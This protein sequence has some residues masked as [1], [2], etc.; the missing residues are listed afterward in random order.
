MIY[1]SLHNHTYYSIQDGFASPKEY[2]ER[3][4]EVGLKAIAITEHGNLYSAPYIHKLRKDYPDL[5]VIYGVEAYECLDHKV[6]DPNNRYFHLIVLAKN[7]KGRVAINKLITESEFE[8]KYYKP[9]MDLSMIKPY[10][11]DLIITSACMAS[12]LHREQDYQKCIEYINEYKSIFNKDNFYLE[13]QSHKSEE[14]AEYN[15]KI[16]KLAKETGT[17]F[18]ITTDSHAATKKQLEY[19]GIFVQI[20][21]DRETMD[22]SYEGCYMQSAEEIHEIMDEQIGW[23]YV[24]LGLETTNYI[25]DLCDQVEMPF[26]E[27]KL[28]PF[29]IPKEYTE[30]S[31]I[32]N[33]IEKGWKTRNFDK[34]NQI[35][36]KIR[37][38][39]IQ[40]ELDT[41]DK[42][43]FIGYFLIVWDY[44]NWGRNN[45]VLFGDGGRGSGAGSIICY[46]LEITGIDPVKYGLIFER[47]L[48]P[49]R[50]GLP[51]LDIDLHPKEKVI[52]YL[53]SRYGI[54]SVCQICNFSYITPNV[55]I[56]DVIRILDKDKKRL[57]K[58]GMTIGTKKSFEIAK[59]F[60]SEKWEDCIAANKTA[61]EK[62]SD[63]IFI[64][65][66]RIAKELSGRVRHVSIH[67]GGVGIVGTEIT[68]YMPMRKTDKGEHVIQVDKKIVEEIG[69][70]KFDL[71]G[72][73]TLSII[74]GTLEV[75]NVEH[76]EIDPN[77]EAFL[78]DKEMFSLIGAGDT[79]NVFQLESQGMKDL[80][81]RLKPQTIREISDILALYRPDS[82]GMLEDYIA[83]KTKKKQ[84]QYIHPDMKKILGETYSALVYQ[85]QVMEITR[86]FGGRSYAGADKFR[87]GIGKKDPAIVQKEATTLKTEIINNG[88]PENI[89]ILISDEMK[90][91]G[92]Y[93]FNKSHSMGYSVISLQT[94]YLKAH[95]QVPFYCAV[96]NACNNDNGKINKYITEAQNH[97]VEISPP[98]I[99][100]SIDNFSVVDGK[101]LFGIGAIN[102][103]GGV[104]VEKIIKERN[105]GKYTGV[106]NFIERVPEV[107]TAQVVMLIKAGAFGTQNK[108][109]L[110][111]KYLKYVVMQKNDNE[112]KEY[113][114]VK[115]LPTLLVLKL[116]YGIDTDVIK[117]KEERLKLYNQIRTERHDTIE[118]EQ[119]K[120]EQKTRQKKEYHKLWEKYS[121]NKDYWE[122]EAI[123]IFLTNNPFRNIYQC[124][125][126][127]FSSAENGQEFFDVGIIS[128]ITKKK[129]KYK[130]TFCFINLY[131]Y[132]GIIE[133]LCFAT[134]YE[135]F[136]DLIAKGN[137]VA[138]FG[139]KSS[140]DTFIVNNI[141]TIDNWINRTNLRIG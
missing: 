33:L 120:L 22:E 53:Q 137:K 129:D 87:K 8:G 76:W 118:F 80:C 61:I 18:I 10:A 139:E 28:P 34:L 113:S 13:M 119:W 27:P 15:R 9:R 23:E 141:E 3:A 133:G 121:N 90:Q 79:G 17:P 30:R 56:K 41:I 49:E 68:D 45:G 75:G 47:F 55:A 52:E 112:Y 32:E 127:P 114:P 72:L 58:Y 21:Q 134:N 126:R 101:I 35:E 14:Q 128:K 2:M 39:R 24:V 86:V 132:S 84:E 123:S 11:D 51:D 46:L 70:V 140:E 57:E 96:L 63:E 115:T 117:N 67:A 104:L 12:K 74:K 83:V 110:L 131:T 106:L 136:T 43:G 93:M 69:I 105:K 7:E 99:N 71:L 85:E 122:F 29:P 130:R 64:D 92:G 138:V 6:Q 60:N 54:M 77:N 124:I 65:V 102:S 73:N 4:K 98:H 44:M 25:A 26:Q 111:S 108:D 135:R 5:K 1:S 48:N 42:M 125:S 66:F 19:Q 78:N 88:Y 81:R 109:I 94:A 82:M 116:E 31:Y 100:N 89:A 37:L 50:V 107:N 16:L 40:Y 91:K 36:Q 103:L 38:E 95:Y 97:G 59:L 20:A 62:Y